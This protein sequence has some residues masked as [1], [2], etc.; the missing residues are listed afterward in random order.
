MKKSFILTLLAGL[1]VSFISCTKCSK[2]DTVAND[3][4][5]T[6]TVIDVYHA[7]AMDRQAMYM[8]F[9]DNY[10]WYETCMRLPEFFDSENVTSEPTILVNIFQSI[11]EFDGGADTYVWKF[12]HFPD[13]TVL[14]DS[15]HSFWIEDFPLNRDT[16]KLNYQAA[17]DRM[18]QAN[19][20]KP[21]SKNVTLRNPIG[22][23]GVNPQW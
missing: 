13:G 1:I 15:I 21:H 18:M 7:I 17:F 5:V 12:Q 20:P 22:I 4:V 14:T 19:L 16:I 23:V 9:K 10:R 3:S 6:A 2:E 8:K 11:E